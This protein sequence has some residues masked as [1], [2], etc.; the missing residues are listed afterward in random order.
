MKNPSLTL[1]FK[2]QVLHTA[3]GFFKRSN[4][5]CIHDHTM[6]RGPKTCNN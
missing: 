2:F 4:P 3:E 6:H 5:K 1:G